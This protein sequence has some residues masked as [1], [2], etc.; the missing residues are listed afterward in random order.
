MWRDGTLMP[1]N[2]MKPVYSPSSSTEPAQAR[3]NGGML[4]TLEPK[5]MTSR[6]RVLA[7]LNHQEP[8]RVPIDLSG[9][10]SSG[11]AAMAYARLR[12]YLGL[13]KKPIRVYDPVQ[14]LALVDED[15]L[16]RFKVDTIELG[17][18][19]ALEDKHWAEW[20]LPDGTPCLMPA[21]ARP[22]RD[23]GAW[24]MRSQVT[25]REIAR[26]P[27]NVWYFEQTHFPFLENDDPDHIEAALPAAM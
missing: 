16:Q 25:G 11:I 15:V 8:D 26:M 6:E 24:V 20:T 17:R 7:A 22:E 23:N 5:V 2:P 14:Q 13:P 27:E 4:E 3:T 21:W 10:R 12:D 18:A 9:H 19:F 1:H